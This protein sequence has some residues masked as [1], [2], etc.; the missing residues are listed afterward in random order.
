MR[1]ENEAKR[2]FHKQKQIDKQAVLVDEIN[3]EIEKENQPIDD[4]GDGGRKR[5]AWEIVDELDEI[6][7]EC[8]ES[9]EEELNDTL[10]DASDS[11]F[12]DLCIAD[13]PPGKMIFT[14]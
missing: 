9:V 2:E 14:R 8:D 11:S 7:S 6:T 1:Q 5:K 4:S 10:N 3:K 13:A 12:N